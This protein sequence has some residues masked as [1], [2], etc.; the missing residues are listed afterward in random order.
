MNQVFLRTLLFNKGILISIKHVYREIYNNCDFPTPSFDIV[1]KIV[2]KYKSTD[3]NFSNFIINHPE[4][5]FFDKYTFL[6]YNINVNIP[7][8]KN[9]AH[10]KKL[11]YLKIN[12]HPI[13]SCRH[14]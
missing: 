14:T 1:N 4:N 6:N 3:T 7:R 13:K 8:R 11:T 12:A 9:V 2:L 5:N 10:K